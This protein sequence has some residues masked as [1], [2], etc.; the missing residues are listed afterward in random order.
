MKTSFWAASCEPGWFDLLQC[1]ALES[2]DCAGSNE[3]R[4]AAGSSAVELTVAEQ[5]FVEI[6]KANRFFSCN[7]LALDGRPRH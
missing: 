6:A 5:Q 4:L 2:Q 7:Y 1:H 3:R